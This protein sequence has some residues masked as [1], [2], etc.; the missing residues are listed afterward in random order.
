MQ[1][2]DVVVLSAAGTALIPP[3]GHAQPD[4]IDAAQELDHRQRLSRRHDQ[5]RQSNRGE[6]C[7]HQEPARRTERDKRAV[8]P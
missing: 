6:R 3:R 7:V 8:R 4:E 2:P 5:G 1:P